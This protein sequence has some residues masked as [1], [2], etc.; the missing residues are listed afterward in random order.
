MSIATTDRAARRRALE[1]R[2]TAM[3]FW[4]NVLMT[5]RVGVWFW[6]IYLVVVVAATYAATTFLGD[7]A[8]FF[9]GE[10]QTAAVFL[11]VLG[12]LTVAQI[13]NVHVLSGGTRRSATRGW[14][15]AAPVLGVSFA[16]MTVLISLVARWIAADQGA[17]L[18]TLAQMLT[19][20]AAL[21]VACT[22]TA[23]AG[24]AVA[25]VYR[26]IGGWPGTLAL[27]V[28]VGPAS[29][30]LV[31]LGGTGSGAIGD[32]ATTADWILGLAAI[33]FTAVMVWLFLR[34]VPIK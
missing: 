4:S 12:I 19:M 22:A 23:L 25:L 24:I 10:G 16:A 27:P 17:E 6:A 2:A 7:G 30:V 3:T 28:T 32:S 13:L 11:F 34:R 29:L 21:T 20:L 14:L 31:R 33:A 26:T 15:L 1:R 5:W 8:M 18:L 9:A